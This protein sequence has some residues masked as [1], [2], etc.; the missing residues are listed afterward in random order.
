MDESSGK[1]QIHITSTPR[2]YSVLV[3]F[4]PLNSS[5]NFF[6]F[7]KK[8]KNRVRS[9]RS[10]SDSDRPSNFA[11]AAPVRSQRRVSSR[12]NPDPAGKNAR[13]VGH[14]QPPHRHRPLSSLRSAIPSQF[15]LWC[16]LFFL[17]MWKFVR[18]S[19]V[20]LNWLQN[21]WWIGSGC[22]RISGSAWP[23]CGRRSARH[24]LRCP[25]IWTPFF[26]LLIPNVWH[27]NYSLGFDW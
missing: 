13:P 21:G 8:G 6:F 3:I 16:I 12:R 24:S 19:H 7:F 20:L 26:R 10:A 1:P 14:S 27:H 23:R 9:R 18:F 25:R 2:H 11:L 17:S 4:F 22:R 15:G 5:N